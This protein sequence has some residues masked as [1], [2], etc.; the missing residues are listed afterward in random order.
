MD[1]SPH[2]FGDERELLSQADY[3]SVRNDLGRIRGWLFSLITMLLLNQATR[4]RRWRFGRESTE[5]AVAFVAALFVNDKIRQ[6]RDN[7][8]Q[9]IPFFTF[10]SKYRSGDCRS[11]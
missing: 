1:I 4:H 5:F 7:S 9:S 11:L 8:S 3:S 2:E 6:K 10:S